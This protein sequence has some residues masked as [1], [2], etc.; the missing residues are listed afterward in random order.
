MTLNPFKKRPAKKVSSR[1]SKSLVVPLEFDE[2]VMFVQWLQLKKLDHFSVPNENNMSK[3]NKKTAIIQGGRA[4]KSGMQSGVQDMVVFTKKKILFI[5]MKRR[6][7][8]L[9]TVSENQ[10]KWAKIVGG[11]GYA[12]PFVAYGCDEAKIFVE[13]YL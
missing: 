3:L 6:S 10:K 9:S 12:E 5:E 8:A 13:K 4:K 1:A 7:M 11:Y 2:Q